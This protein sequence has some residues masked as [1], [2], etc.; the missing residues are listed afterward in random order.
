MATIGQLNATTDY[1]WQTKTPVDILSKQSALLWKLTNTAWTEGNWSIQP[2]ELV[3]GGLMIKVPFKF[4]G[5]NRGGYGVNTVINQSKKTLVDNLRFKLNSGVVG[6]NTLNLL[7]QIQNAGE[8]ETISLTKLYLADIA[9]AARIQLAED[10]IASAAIH[11]AAGRNPDEHI[12]GLGDLF[13]Y[14]NTALEYGAIAEASVPQWKANVIT[15]AESISFTTLQ[16]IWRAPGFGSFK[17]LLPNFCCTTTVLKDG[18]EAS[19]HPQQVTHDADIKNVAGFEN[20]VFRG[21][22]IVADPYYDANLTGT[23]DALNLNF[24]HL[25]AHKDKNF[26][27]P[28]WIAM[29]EG[30]QP[31]VW[32]ANTRFIGNLIC[33]NRQMN[34]RHINMSVDE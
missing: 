33:S 14:S 20:I 22:P 28:E 11:T 15:T 2:H 16:T 10:I 5:S 25:K 34:V 17:G 7:D 21:A 24:L 18:F 30:G 12:N 6:S 19:L 3:D 29:K 9:Q 31:D 32:T 13:Q 8:A 23:F 4:Q 1:F 27:T 26:T